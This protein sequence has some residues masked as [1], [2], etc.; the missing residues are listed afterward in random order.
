MAA[1]GL[2]GGHVMDMLGDT[3]D[4]V[5]AVEE[6]GD[7]PLRLR[8]APW[9]VPGVDADGLAELADLQRRGGRRWRSAASSS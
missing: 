4:V 3:G 5:E 2:T 1:T 6:R 8:F 7:L 9:C